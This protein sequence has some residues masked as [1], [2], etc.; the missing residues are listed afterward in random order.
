M[1]AAAE[2]Q[3]NSAVD[4]SRRPKRFKWPHWE[5]DFQEEVAFG[6]LLQEHRDWFMLNPRSRH[7]A[8]HTTA[9]PYIPQPC[10]TYLLKDHWL[11]DGQ[12]RGSSSE[13]R[14]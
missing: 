1:G 7:S 4:G 9:V 12:G 5:V 6:N 14:T 13:L 11:K 3:L 2:K 10:H 8:R